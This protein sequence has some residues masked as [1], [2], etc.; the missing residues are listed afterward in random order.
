MEVDEENEAYPVLSPDGKMEAYIE[1]YNVVVHE[2]G[3][4]YTEAKR[5]LTQDGTMVAI[6]ATASNGVQTASTSSYA[7]VCR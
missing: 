2:A 4:P 5:I 7:S 6:T 1:G 3:K